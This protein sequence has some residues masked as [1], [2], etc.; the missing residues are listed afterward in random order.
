MFALIDY[1][2]L[3]AAN[4]CLTNENSP[5]PTHLVEELKDLNNYM[6]LNEIVVEQL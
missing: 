4:M 2:R 6:S 5:T 3:N 1:K